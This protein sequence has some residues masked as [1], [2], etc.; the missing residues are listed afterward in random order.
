MLVL[1]VSVSCICSSR[2]E[3]D[4]KRRSVQSPSPLEMGHPA[5]DLMTC[6]EL[7]LRPYC[8]LREDSGVIESGIQ[9]IP[10]GSN[11]SSLEGQE[12]Q[13]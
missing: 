8:A 5:L 3:A 2:L 12:K 13:D 4:K 7:E 1:Y 9:Q 11:G 10:S 6:S